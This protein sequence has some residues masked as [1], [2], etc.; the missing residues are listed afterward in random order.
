[1]MT[2]NISALLFLLPLSFVRAG[3]PDRQLS[4]QGTFREEVSPFTINVDHEFIDATKQRVALTRTPIGIEELGTQ[5]GP[6]VHN[7]TTVR[8]YWVNKYDWFEVQESL[9]NQSVSPCLPPTSQP[10]P[11]PPPHPSSKP[12]S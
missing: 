11:P 6:S 3:F 2:Y 8:D 10:P 4:F 7:A 9:N 1:M 12:Q 5:E